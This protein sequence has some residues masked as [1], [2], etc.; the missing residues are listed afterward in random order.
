MQFTEEHKAFRKVVGEF[1]ETEINPYTDQWE[2]DR[3]FPAHELFPKLAGIGA[4]GLEYDEAY[5]GQGA[6][7]LDYVLNKDD[8]AC[9]EGGHIRASTIDASPQTVSDDTRAAVTGLF[10]L[11]TTTT[12]VVSMTIDDVGGWRRKLGI[13]FQLK[14]PIDTMIITATSAGIACFGRS[15]PTEW[16]R[17][18]RAS[19][20]RATSTARPPRPRG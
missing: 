10:A 19:S 7:L 15:T 17:S 11:A 3:T 20:G 12:T 13:E 18:V 6:D 8:F 9:D 1:I 4:L 5:G 2:A 14:V 16:S